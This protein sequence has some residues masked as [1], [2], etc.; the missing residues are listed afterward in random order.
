MSFEKVEWLIDE[1]LV[2][3]HFLNILVIMEIKA[4][5]EQCFYI[6]YVYYI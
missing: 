4:T 3:L 2:A 6:K 1:Y 5:A